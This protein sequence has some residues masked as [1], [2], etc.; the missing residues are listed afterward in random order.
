[1]VEFHCQYQPKH[2]RGQSQ[3]WCHH[4]LLFKSH[5]LFLA[6][7]LLTREPTLHYTLHKCRTFQGVVGCTYRHMHTCTMCYETEGLDFTLNRRWR[8]KSQMPLE[9]H[10]RVTWCAWCQRM[11]L[12]AWKLYLYL[13]RH[14][15]FFGECSC[16]QSKLSC[17]TCHV[18][19]YTRGIQAPW[20]SPLP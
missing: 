12:W 15:F 2:C 9:K 3:S 16:W 1:M 19:I 13:N 6:G 4:V 17:T 7:T 20:M 10:I 8:T 18:V 14:S 11:I 5:G